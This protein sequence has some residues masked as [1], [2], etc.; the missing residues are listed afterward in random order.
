MSPQKQLEYNKG[1][2]M[3][4]VLNNEAPVYI[5]L[6]CTHTLPHAIP[7]LGTISL[8]WLAKDKYSKQIYPSL[9]L[10]Y[11]TTYLWQSDLVSHSALSSENLVHTLKQLYRM[12]CDIILLGKERQT[13]VFEWLQLQWL[14]IWDT[15]YTPI[16]VRPVLPTA[17]ESFNSP[18]PLLFF[19][20]IGCFRFLFQ[21]W[22]YELIRCSTALVTGCMFI[23]CNRVMYPCVHVALWTRCFV[24]KF[25]CITFHSL[26]YA[27]MYTNDASNFRFTQQ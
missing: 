14:V 1:L 24:W 7:T 2:F 19:I 21:Y 3:Y 12:D 10:Y 26:I 15:F 18:P 5:Y 27:Y 9:V 4:R 8:V 11:G 16:E 23:M 22:S 17:C 6:I 13:E 25:S 20:S